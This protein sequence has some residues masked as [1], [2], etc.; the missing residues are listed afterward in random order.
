MGQFSSGSLHLK[1]DGH[2][3]WYNWAAEISLENG[4]AGSESRNRIVSDKENDPYIYAAEH[5]EVAL[6]MKGMNL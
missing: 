3:T 6:P 5:D 4:K 1:A 2:A